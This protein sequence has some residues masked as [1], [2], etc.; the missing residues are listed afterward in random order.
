M[1]RFTRVGRPATWVVAG[2]LTVLVA[3]CG[4]V[5]G[6]PAAQGA[7]PMAR[8]TLAVAATSTATGTAG[9]TAAGPA[10]GDVNPSDGAVNVPTSTNSSDNIVT[11]TTVTATFSEPMDPATIESSPAG[12]QLTFTLAETSGNDVAGTVTMNAAHTTATFTPTSSALAP[13]TSYTATV[14]TAATS[15]G[16]VAIAQVFA[17]TF[18]TTAIGYTAQAPV[19]LGTSGTFA[20]LTQTGVT[21]VYAS[22]ING[23]VGASPI[24]GAAIG[25]TC[26]EVMTGIVYTVD[27]AGPPCKVTNATLLTTAVGD[28]AIAYA[29]AAGR[30]FPDFIDLGAGEIG[31]LTL[32][33]GLY[34]WTTG[35][36][37]STDV[38]L[39]GGPN[40]VWIFQIAGNIDQA[41]AKNVNLSGGAQAKNVFW[42]TAGAGSIGTTAHFEGTILAKTMIAM[43]TGASTNG[44]LLAQTAVTLQKNTV[45]Q[46]AS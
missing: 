6:E 30:T 39:A 43:K 12:A 19:E 16:G 46:P 27:A 10:V 32:L 34:Q 20:I 28:M 33:P 35:V 13:N 42:Q 24:T 44:R 11:G 22:A 2:L 23:N 3:G 40:D 26:P 18:T 29:D 21:N 38:T 31:G 37:M 5:A 7:G 25:L 36:S 15:A 8:T 1:F 41:S 9:V 17:W 4:G 14:S 45:T